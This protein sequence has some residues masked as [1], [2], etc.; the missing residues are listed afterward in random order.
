MQKVSGYIV[1]G[2]IVY[3]I[4]SP[5]KP[6]PPLPYVAAMETRQFIMKSYHEKAE[7]AHPGEY[8]M[9]ARILQTFWWPTL[10]QDVKEFCRNCVDCHRTKHQIKARAELQP[11]KHKGAWEFVHLITGENSPRQNQGTLMYW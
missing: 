5:G 1:R 9:R 4:P 7:A 6:H 8:K 10:V 2:G 11:I 3:K